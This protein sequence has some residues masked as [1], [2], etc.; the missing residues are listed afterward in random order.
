MIRAKNSNIRDIYI[1]ST[2]NLYSRSCSH[3]NAYYNENNSNHNYKLYQFIR[4]HGGYRRWEIVEIQKIECSK[5]EADLKER[6]LILL[7]NATLNKCLPGRTEQDKVD[8][9]RTYQ[10]KY[11]L[12]DE[13]KEY[14]KKYYQTRK[15]ANL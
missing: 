1:G 5:S 12:T 14:H 9:N 13:C 6:Q 2:K 7:L 8:Y 4:R 11:R 10:E 3:K 15:N